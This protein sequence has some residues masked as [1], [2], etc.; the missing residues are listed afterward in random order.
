MKMGDTMLTPLGTFAGGNALD[1]DALI[2]QAQR[3]E[4]RAAELPRGREREPYVADALDLRRLA[5][6]TEVAT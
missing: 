1:R 2:A 6:L 3:Y 5:A 4:L